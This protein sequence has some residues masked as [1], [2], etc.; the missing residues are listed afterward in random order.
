MGV[1]GRHDDETTEIV[2]RSQPL[3]VVP[4]MEFIYH[5]DSPA[6]S[7]NRQLAERL[8]RSGDLFRTADPRGGLLLLHLGDTPR[9]LPV[10][11]DKQLLAVMSDRVRFVVVQG[12]KLKGSR[13]PTSDLSSM[14]LS[15]SFLSKFPTLDRLITEPVYLP[16]WQLPRPGYADGGPGNRIF[17]LGSEAPVH[18]ELDAI[19]RFLDCMAFATESDATN[20]VA[21]ALTVMGR[22]LY[23]GDKPCFL[24]TANR[25]HSGKGTVADFMSGTSSTV[26]MTYESKDWA[27]ERKVTAV[28]Q[29]RRDLAVLS[30]DNIRL[31]RQGD[32]VRSAFLESLL[33]QREPTL[34]APGTRGP[35]SVRSNFVVFATLNEG[36]FSEDMMNRAVSIRLHVTGDLSE[37]KSAIGNPK[38]GFLPKYR[39]RIAGELRGMIEKWKAAGQPLAEPRHSFTTWSQEIGGILKVN[40]FKSFLANAATRRSEDDPVRRA[41]AVLG[42]HYPNEWLRTDDWVARIIRMGL[43]KQLIPA[44][45]R[46]S[47]PGRVRGTGVVFTNHLDETLN[48]E[49]EDEV[50]SLTLRKVRRRFDS[51]EPQ[52]RYQF[53]I[54]GRR[55]VPAD[56][57]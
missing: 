17:Y 13:V 23:A 27:M 4:Q 50:T 52:T 28:L 22:N 35:V 47:G 20:A 54:V 45:D 26:Q 12:G 40:G 36:R 46:G 10:T 8:S 48:I 55:Q 21:G 34:Y 11:T 18:S 24:I 19:P 2:Q 49:T 56:D 29:S 3:S 6:D 42:T 33:H 9:V 38:N 57:E 44:A 31:D 53:E 5:A 7:R 37:R 25:S 30:L 51:G 43:D 14:L 15:E 32:Q 39:D 1:T 41:L 16:S